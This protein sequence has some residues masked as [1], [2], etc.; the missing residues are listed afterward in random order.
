[1]TA[2]VGSIRARL[3]RELNDPDPWTVMLIAALGALF[4]PAVLY[5]GYWTHPFPR[6]VHPFTATGQYNLWLL[7]LSAQTALWAL[8]LVPLTQSLRALWRSGDG[9]WLR[10]AASTLLLVA[11][12]AGVRLPGSSWNFGDDPHRLMVRR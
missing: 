9:Q 5:W 10:I 12:I 7:L 3:E 2:G 4:A 1:M 11:L 6:S 8:A